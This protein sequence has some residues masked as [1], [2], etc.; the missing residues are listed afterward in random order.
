MP[1]NKK[2]EI[3][4]L[5]VFHPK[6]VFEES[7]LKDPGPKVPCSKTVSGRNLWWRVIAKCPKAFVIGLGPALI[8][9]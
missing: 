6:E 1:N 5:K 8:A 9:P 3:T 4:V 2:V 7:P